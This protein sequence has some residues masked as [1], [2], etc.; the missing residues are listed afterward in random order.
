MKSGDTANFEA[1][2]VQEA[3]FSASPVEPFFRQSAAIALF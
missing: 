1:R 2:L 3:T